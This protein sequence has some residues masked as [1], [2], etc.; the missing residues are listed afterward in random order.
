MSVESIPFLALVFSLPARNA[1]ERMRAWRA[2]KAMGGVVLRDG[3]YLLPAKTAQN[4]RLF[5]VANDIQTSGGMAEVVGILP[6]SPNQLEAFRTLF[7]RSGEYVLLQTDMAQLDP[8]RADLTA[9]KRTLRGMRRRFSE[10]AA[11][12]FF[13]GQ[14][15]EITAACL[16]TLETVLANRLNPDEPTSDNR[17]IAPLDLKNYQSKV[18]VTRADLWI[19]RLASAWLIQRFIDPDA[20][21]LWLSSSD[22]PP[23]GA[24]GFD[25]DGAQ[26]T[27]V[28]SYVTFETLLASFGLEKNTA[29]LHL[30]RMIHALDVGGHSLEAAGF[31]AL[32]SGMKI[33][34]Q[35]DDVLFS[36]VQKILDDYFIYFYSQENSD[37]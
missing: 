34:I 37:G 27:H 20:R 3:V 1:T 2:L 9:L 24:I 4:E 22:M 36:T 7:D 18:W 33:R 31:S 29:L 25:F 32:V 19:D 21:F 10:I 11:I 5:S 12:D 26:F 14:L 16:T 28:G 6:H 30:G 17:V 35:D 15:Q 23:T 13:P 8:E